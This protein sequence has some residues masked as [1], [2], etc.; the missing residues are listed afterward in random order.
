MTNL[1][2]KRQTGN[3]WCSKKKEGKKKRKK[4]R[5]IRC[6]KKK[7]DWGKWKHNQKKHVYADVCWWRSLRAGPWQ[8]SGASSKACISRQFSQPLFSCFPQ[9]AISLIAKKARRI[10][11]WFPQTP[12][13]VAVCVCG[14]ISSFDCYVANTFKR[15]FSISQLLWTAVVCSTVPADNKGV[16]RA[17]GIQW[18]VK[19]SM[20][21]LFALLR[22]IDQYCFKC[23]H[24]VLKWK[25]MVA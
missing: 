24:K 10:S 14:R 15:D 11:C 1:S 23:P 13:L 12:Y 7:V 9:G 17:A 20:V 6:K 19:T 25:F 5:K 4:K 3:K 2:N 21:V 8:A 18:L 22:W 16:I